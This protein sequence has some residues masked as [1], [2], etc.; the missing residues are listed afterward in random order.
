MASNHDIYSGKEIIFNAC[1][2]DKDANIGFRK[3]SNWDNILINPINVSQ[4]KAGENEYN[5]MSLEDRIAL[6]IPLDIVWD[7]GDFLATVSWISLPNAS[8]AL[9]YFLTSG[10]RGKT[11]KVYPLEE[12]LY[13]EGH[14]MRKINIES[15]INKSK[16]LNNDFENCINNLE[17][18]AEELCHTD[19]VPVTFTNTFESS[20]EVNDN[21]DWHNAMHYYRI[22]MECTAVKNGN[23]FEMD[24]KYGIV[25]YYDWALGLA[26]YGDSFS[27]FTEDVKQLF[28]NY[29]YM[30]NMAGK[31]RNYTNYGEYNVTVLWNK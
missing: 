23:D 7:L 3:D 28:I 21:K 17:Y 20:G 13:K 12:G 18:I 4:I 24:L 2:Y 11:D 9:E 8:T 27:E 29:F 31:A 19:G 5:S 25:D 30:L 26:N 1:I 15:A 22:K 16:D 6:E 10:E 14:T